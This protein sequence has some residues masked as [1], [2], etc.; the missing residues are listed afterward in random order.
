MWEVQD[1]LLVAAARRAESRLASLRFFFFLSF[2]VSAIE[3]TPASQPASNRSTAQQELAATYQNFFFFLWCRVMLF[4]LFGPVYCGHIT[5][6]LYFAR[7]RQSRISG[8]SRTNSPAA[9]LEEER[10][11]QGAGVV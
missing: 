8:T 11:E 10:G 7:R 2:L 5:A 6:P 1:L 9:A 4:P 3:E